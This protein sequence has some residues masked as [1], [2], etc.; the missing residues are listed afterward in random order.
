MRIGLSSRWV[1]VWALLLSVSLSAAPTLYTERGDAGA[2]TP[3][4]TKGSAL[5]GIRGSLSTL[6][7][8]D[9]FQIRIL[10]PLNFLLFT[11][12]S[13]L[14]L[15]VDDPQLFLF[16]QQGRGVYSNDDYPNACALLD[17]P[18]PT[19]ATQSGFS[20]PPFATGIYWLAI[21]RANIEPLGAAGNLFSDP[22]FNT[23]ALNLPVSDEILSN[24]DYAGV[25]S[26]NA[27]RTNYVI[28]TSGTY[29]AIP[30]PGTMSMM[31][32][33]GLTVLY[34]ARRRK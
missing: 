9:L 33:G 18:G 23:T 10:E 21:T 14:S 19:C 28:L 13:P 20:I 6:E 8:V 4:L 7:D 27:D 1:L 17:D 25:G 12:S 29:G 5:L 30:E 22:L 2:L 26:V 15:T 16:N 24:W 3:Q 11:L 32:V 34:A 31:L